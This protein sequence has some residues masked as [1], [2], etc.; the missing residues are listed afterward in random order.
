[1]D[2]AVVMS[3]MNFCTVMNDMS[4]ASSSIGPVFIELCDSLVKNINTS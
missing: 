3:K 4:L 1:M 2:N